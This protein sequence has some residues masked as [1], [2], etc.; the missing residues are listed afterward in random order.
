MWVN[1][2]V[3]AVR[4]TL[5]VLPDKQTSEAAVGVSQKVPLADFKR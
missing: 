4:R 3:L 2:V 5:P 1:R